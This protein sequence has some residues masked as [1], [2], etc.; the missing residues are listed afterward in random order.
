VL[1][2]ATLPLRV[3]AELFEHMSFSVAGNEL[4]LCMPMPGRDDETREGRR[5]FHFIWFRTVSY[6]T[7]LPE[8]CTDATGKCHGFSIAPPLIRAEVIASLREAARRTLPPQMASM[9]EL[10]RQ[11]LLQPVYDLESPHVVAGR[12]ALV[13]D[14]AFVAR[15]HVATGVTKAALDAQCLVDALESCAGDIDAGLQRFDAAREP[16][17]RSL[18]ARARVLGSYLSPGPLTGEAERVA[19]EHRQPEAILRE[20]GA[21]GSVHDVQEAH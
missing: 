8:L 13:G 19:A 4:F 5:R 7:E 14:A 10:V 15:P 11:P 3:H 21:A 9:V 16:F 2:E 20:Y 6:D 18:V 1:D 17:G 12:V